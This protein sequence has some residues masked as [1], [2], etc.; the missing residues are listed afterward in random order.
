MYSP[1]FCCCES[2]V[3]RL[4]NTVTSGRLASMFSST[5]CDKTGWIFSSVE[6]PELFANASCLDSKVRSA[7]LTTPSDAPK[8]PHSVLPEAI[9]GNPQY[10]Q[11]YVVKIQTSSEL[12]NGLTEK[13][14]SK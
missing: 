1:R 2:P 13:T 7:A 8:A 3:S 9:S 6:E 5:L 4:A 12:T 11:I 14:S 10:V